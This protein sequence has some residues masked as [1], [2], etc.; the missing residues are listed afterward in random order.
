MSI[1]LQTIALTKFLLSQTVAT[2][3]LLTT[4][5]VTIAINDSGLEIRPLIVHL[6]FCILI[7]RVEIVVLGIPFPPTDINVRQ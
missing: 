1:G 6:F 3:G 7:L 2:L 4:R 5:I